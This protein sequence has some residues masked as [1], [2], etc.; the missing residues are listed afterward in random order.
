MIEV[1]CFCTI[2]MSSII[3]IYQVSECFFKYK[4]LQIPDEDAF[5]HVDVILSWVIY[6]SMKSMYSRL[7]V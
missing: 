3:D 6:S 2:Y 7:A 5:L 4:H 1:L